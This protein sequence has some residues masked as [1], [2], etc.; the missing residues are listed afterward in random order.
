MPTYGLESIAEKYGFNSVDALKWFFY[1]MF[2]DL[3]DED[4]YP[5]PRE[6]VFA[7]IQA[8]GPLLVFSPATHEACLIETGKALGLVVQRSGKP[9]DHNDAAQ[10]VNLTVSVPKVEEAERQA[11][12]AEGWSP[13]AQRLNHIEDGLVEVRDGLRAVEQL[14]EDFSGDHTARVYRIESRVDRLEKPVVAKAVAKAVSHPKDFLD[15]R[16]RKQLPRNYWTP[17]ILDAISKITRATFTTREIQQI[18]R[19]KTKGQQASISCSLHKMAREGKILVVKQGTGHRATE[20]RA[21]KGR[22]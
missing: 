7:D 2:L 16:D 1:D 8:H 20:F 3:R 11:E 4:R 13:T 22:V 18:L 19:P 17:R 15:T 9:D 21:K 6:H 12:P 14:L 5:V 10:I